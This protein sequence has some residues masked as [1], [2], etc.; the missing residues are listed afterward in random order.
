[1][2]AGTP[3]STVPFATI[4]A[5]VPPIEAFTEEAG[6][7]EDTVSALSSFVGGNTEASAGSD[8]APVVSAVFS[9]A[10][11]EDG[12]G[13]DSVSALFNATVVI[14]EAVQGLDTNAVEPSVFN[15][16]MGE[17]VDAGSIVPTTAILYSSVLNNAIAADTIPAEYLWEL[18]NDEQDGN[19]AAINSNQ[20][21]GW[22]TINDA[23]TASWQNIDTQD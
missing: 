1:M 2:F 17:F 22:T 6:A 10:I 15:I 12:S 14:S 9:T 18:I 20:T 5:F 7:V 3:Y 11:S 23:Q 19:W 21:S 8:S 4:R 16:V 13:A